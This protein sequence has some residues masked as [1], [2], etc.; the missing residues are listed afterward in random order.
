M[1]LPQQL[2]EI[3]KR[4]EDRI[5]P[6]VIRDVIAEIR[7]GRGVDRRN[8]HCIDAKSR[9]VV[10]PLADAIK[11]ADAVGVAVLKGPRIYLVDNASLPPKGIR[12]AWSP[13]TAGIAGIINASGG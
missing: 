7:H 3:R 9:Q 5:D 8:P 12:H 1:H 13:A 11:V 4:T 10:K 2:I 6:A